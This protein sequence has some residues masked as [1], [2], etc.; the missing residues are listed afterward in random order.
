MGNPKPSSKVTLALLCLGLLL[1]GAGDS[2]MA[3]FLSEHATLVGM[4]TSQYGI[5]MGTNSIVAITML[6]V[7]AKLTMLNLLN[8]KTFLILGYLIDASGMLSMVVVYYA[9]L[10]GTAFF[11]ALLSLRVVQSLG[12]SIGFSLVYSL[13]GSEL[14]DYSH[15]A[16][17]FLECMYGIGLTIGPGI[18][19]ALYDMGGFPLPFV[20]L[21]AVLYSVVVIAYIFL[22]RSSS[23]ASEETGVSLRQLVRPTILVCMLMVAMSNIVDTFNDSTFARLLSTFSLSTTAVGVSFFLPAGSY[24]VSSLLS[25]FLIERT[26]TRRLVLLLCSLSAIGSLLFISPIVPLSSHPLWLVY[27]SEVMLGLSIGPFYVYCFLLI[28]EDLSKITDVKT[29]HTA[30]AAVTNWSSFVGCFIGP[31]LGNC[32]LEASS[33]QEASAVITAIA[34]CVTIIYAFFTIFKSMQDDSKSFATSTVA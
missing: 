9:G 25:G 24:T 29:A 5:I 23:V 11:L 26:S 33:L 4:T 3:S 13:S 19:G 12:A 16:V 6:P 20:C 1:Q 22:P 8:D 2:H 30:T 28:C 32:I 21:S 27:V 10:E 34:A 31:V 15:I 7:I 17:P 14:P 18:S